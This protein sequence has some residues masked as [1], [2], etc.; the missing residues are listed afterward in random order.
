MATDPDF[1]ASISAAVD[2]R[3]EQSIDIEKNLAFFLVQLCCKGD[4]SSHRFDED[5]QNAPAHGTGP[6]SMV[7]LASI[8][9]GFVFRL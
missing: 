8:Y 5:T 1:V 9:E 4:G 2:R 6:L 3:V 7:D